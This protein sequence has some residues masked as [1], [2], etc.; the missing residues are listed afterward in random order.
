MINK[1]YLLKAIVFR[2]FAS[3]LLFLICIIITREIKISIV[4]L[5]TEFI[6]K[7]VLYYFYEIGWEKI[8]KIFGVRPKKM[9]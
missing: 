7:I 4:I 2:I 5:I 3:L 1:K 8:T 9:L 6:L